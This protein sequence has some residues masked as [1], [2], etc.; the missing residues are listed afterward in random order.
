MIG[1]LGGGF[2]DVEEPNG[3]VLGLP[4]R[5][6]TLMSLGFILIFSL[7]LIISHTIF[8]VSSPVDSAG[9]AP[10]P[11]MMVDSRRP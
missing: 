5:C 11:D 10:G 1:R 2:V 3:E 9:S 8:V 7:D 6:E 4:R